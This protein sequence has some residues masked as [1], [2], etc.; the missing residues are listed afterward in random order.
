MRL[1]IWGALVNDGG[2][3]ANNTQI[4][5]YLLTTVGRSAP[6]A[7]TLAAA[8]VALD[9]ETGGTAQEGGFLWRLAESAANQL[10]VNLVGLA[11]IGLEY[12]L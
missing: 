6:D 5:T 8:V 10:Q 2:A 9:A 4:A 1:D 3:G 12:S 7:A 11:Q